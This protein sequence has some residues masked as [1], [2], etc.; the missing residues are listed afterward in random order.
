MN[1]LHYLN[2]IIGFSL[3]MLLLSIVTSFAA[4]MWLVLF[5]TKGRAVGNGLASMLEDIGFEKP[6]AKQ[7]VDDLLNKGSSI[8]GERFAGVLSKISAYFLAGA[9]KNIGREEFV[10]LLLRKA[11]SEDELAKKLGF[12]DAATA[13]NKLDLLE[14]EILLE[15]TKDSMLPAQVWRTKAMQTVVPELASKI[16]ARFDEVLDRITEDVSM[17]GKFLGII[18]TLP[19]LLI[20]WPVDSI[21]LLN[22]LSKDPVLSAKVADVAERNLPSFQKALD[23]SKKCQENN[24]NNPDVRLACEQSDQAL[25]KLA[26]DTMNLSEVGGLFGNEVKKDLECKLPILNIPISFDKDCKRAELT[27]GIFVTWILVSL[28]SAFW[29][30]LLNKMLGIRSEFSKKLDAQREFRANNN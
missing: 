14:Q 30:G 10:L 11:S 8:F 1:I 18:I 5:K 19:I 2:V 20:Y 21:D 28:G 23:E 16:F 6:I 26:I 17:F 24:K 29:L 22:R 25:N 9:P 12:D 15:E 13:K 27:S 4:Q 3:V 7:N